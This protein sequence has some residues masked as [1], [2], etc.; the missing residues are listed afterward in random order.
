MTQYLHKLSIDF[1]LW[2]HCSFL[3][4]VL[5]SLLDANKQVFNSTRNYTN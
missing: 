3:V 4:S 2:W 5:L 1:E